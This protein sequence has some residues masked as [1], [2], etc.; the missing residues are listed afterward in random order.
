[1]KI[2]EVLDRRGDLST[3]VIH[4]TKD[5]GDISALNNLV[6]IFQNLTI[7][8]RSPMGIAKDMDDEFNPQFRSQRV[9]CFTETPLEHIY[10]F[11]AQ[12]EEKRNCEFKP[13]G[14]GLT[15]IQARNLNVNPVWYIDKTP[16]TIWLHNPEN[17]EPHAPLTELIVDAKKKGNF[18]SSAISKV[19]P[20]IEP[21]GTWG[22]HNR[23]FWWEREWRHVGNFKFQPYSI[24]FGLC[25]E[26]QIEPFEKWVH[27]LYGKA[28]PKYPILHFIDPRWGLEEIIARLAG[29]TRNDITP[30][31]P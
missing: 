7:E 10:S 13:Y 31:S 28:Y 5:K 6:S 23:E 9:V 2:K 17:Q 3:F 24:A 26:E 20:Y 30:F 25:E 29:K 16:G 21:M 15:K 14:I 27:S 4:L 12:L 1:M 11:F 8:A 22:T 19:T 18:H